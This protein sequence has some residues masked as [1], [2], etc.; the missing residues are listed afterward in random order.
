MNLFWT[1]PWQIFFLVGFSKSAGHGKVFELVDSPETASLADVRAKM[2]KLEI[3]AEDVTEAVEWARRI[4][5][6]GRD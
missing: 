1:E 2:K 6:A 3:V 4:P 5:H